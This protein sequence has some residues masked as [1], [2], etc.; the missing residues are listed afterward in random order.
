[1]GKGSLILSIAKVN[2]FVMVS[3]GFSKL[4]ENFD[5]DD[6]TVTKAFINSKSASFETY[7][8]CF[9]NQDKIFK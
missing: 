6:L 2:S 5:L 7:L 4:K 8:I 3:R 9:H 1:M